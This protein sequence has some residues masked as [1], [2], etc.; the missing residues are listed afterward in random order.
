MKVLNSP[1]RINE[2][3][4]KVPSHLTYINSVN[5]IPRTNELNM[6]APS[7]LFYINS[8]NTCKYEGPYL[9]MKALP[10]L[11]CFVQRGRIT[12]TQ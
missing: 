10:Y 9:N 11:L 1:P 5:I 4:V 6:K 3:N 12:K 7:H 2:I 8:V